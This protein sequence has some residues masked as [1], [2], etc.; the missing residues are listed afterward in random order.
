V[1]AAREYGLE[2]ILVGDEGVIRRELARHSAEGLRISI[3]HASQVIGMEEH[4]MAVKEKRDASMVVAARLVRQGQADG[5]CSAGNSGAVMAA[6]LFAIGRIRGIDRPALGTVYPAAS[7]P[8]LLLDMGAN[9]DPKPENL[10]Q[11]AVMG[12]IYAERIMG[13]PR[14]R[15]GI[16]SNGEEEDKGTILTREAQKLLKAHPT[17]NYVGCVEGKDVPRGMADVVVTDGFVGNVMVKL[18]EGLVVFFARLLKKEFTQGMLNKLALVLLIPG[19]V[20]MVP[21][22]LLFGPTL[23]RLIRRMDYAEYGGAP[24]LGVDGVVVIGHGRSNAKAIKNMIRVAKESV[25]H[26]LV[27]TIRQ[28][29]AEMQREALIEE[30]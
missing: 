27:E 25:E 23:R 5:F 7:T 16:I 19:L 4:T 6:A 10:L 30:R 13:I 22:I 3:V 18:T 15:V 28:G 9:T 11:F 8:L 24:L 26:N 1:R 2:I 29:I 17:L 14:P 12:S 20:A 21:G